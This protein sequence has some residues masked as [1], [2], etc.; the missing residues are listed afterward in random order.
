MMDFSS[1]QKAPEGY[2]LL[3]SRQ[4]IQDR[5]SEIIQNFA[6]KH[7]LEGVVPVVVLGGAMEWS[8]LV[9]PEL[10]KEGLNTERYFLQA[11]SY[12]GTQSG[13]CNVQLI[14]PGLAEA[15]KGKTALLIEDIVDTGNTA[16]TIAVELEN[17]GVKDVVFLSMLDKPSK[18]DPAIDLT[19]IDVIS[20]FEI[21]GDYFVIG[22][23]LDLDG[24][25][26]HFPG[27]CMPK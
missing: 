12:E 27:I 17:Y 24:K 6:K 5:A 3:Y 20:A 2:S 16:S 18:R 15:L 1:Q 19:G 21:P 10:Y 25:Y 4:D 9:L 23:G 13:N 22:F 8:S 11:K 7:S 26:R 14:T